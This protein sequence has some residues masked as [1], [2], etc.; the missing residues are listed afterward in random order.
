MSNESRIKLLEKRLA[1][2]QAL[3]VSHEN[4]MRILK[5]K[6]GI[7]FEIMGHRGDKK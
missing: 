6:M 2:V 4:D 3:A 7:L 1:D 5:T